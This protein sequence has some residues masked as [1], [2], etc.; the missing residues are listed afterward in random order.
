MTGEGRDDIIVE[1]SEGA[2]EELKPEGQ[3]KMDIEN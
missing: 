3:R 2:A 1:L